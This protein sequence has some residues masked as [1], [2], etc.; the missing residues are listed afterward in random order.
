MSNHDLSM[1]FMINDM[2]EAM[3]HYEL[4]KSDYYPSCSP[5]FIVL[6]YDN[7]YADPE[8]YGFSTLVCDKLIKSLPKQIKNKLGLN[9]LKYLR[10]DYSK[11]YYKGEYLKDFK[12]GLKD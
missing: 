2:Q 8:H 1:F 4:L 9:N 3:K 12:L 7:Q 6:K 11:T 10:S 5:E